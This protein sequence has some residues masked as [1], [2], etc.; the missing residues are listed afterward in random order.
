MK[1]D[2]HLHT[3]RHSPDSIMSPQVLVGRAREIGLDGVVIT[4]H[5]WLWTEEE[6]D[7]LRAAAPGLVVLAGI[8]VSTRQG[9]FL[10]YGVTNPFAVPHGIGVAELCREVHRQG[11]AVV[12]AHPYRWNQ[13]FD[14]ILR[15]ERPDLDG[16]ELMSNNMDGDVR[17]R[18]AALHARLRLAGLGNSDAHRV[19]VL[20]CCYTE[21]G[22]TIRDTC[23][24]V[25]A[26]RAGKTAAFDRAAAPLAASHARRPE[27]GG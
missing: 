11:G 4:E 1:F 20:G 10:A 21:F 25:E 6:L 24:L 8:E 12:A 22:A 23:D 27:G 7:E 26:I 19:E 5:D 3:S 13:P 16:L 15:E 9:H 17:R 2:L 14:D 18:A